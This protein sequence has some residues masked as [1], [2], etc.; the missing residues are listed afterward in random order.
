M[1]ERRFVL[2]DFTYMD[3]AGFL[4][5][6]DAG[7]KCRLSQAVAHAATKRELV[8]KQRPPDWVPVGEFP[9]K[10]AR[11]LFRQTD[12]KQQ[13]YTCDSPMMG[14]SQAIQM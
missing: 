1:S 12:K 7:R 10:F 4:R 11:G 14:S 6:Y 13:N 3:R 5:L 2:A 9:T 8:A